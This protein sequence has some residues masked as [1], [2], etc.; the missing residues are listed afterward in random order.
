MSMNKVRLLLGSLP[1]LLVA[2]GLT[3]WLSIS[4]NP[5]YSGVQG[6]PGKGA[7][8]ATDDDD[9]GDSGRR[10]EIELAVKSDYSR[11]RVRKKDNVRTLGFVRDNGDEVI[12]SMVDLDRPH[13]LII[14]YTRFMFLS[15]LF[16][17]KQEKVLIVG[18]GGGAMIHFLKHYDPKVKIDVVEIDPKI[19]EIADKYFGVRSGG[20][21]NIITKDAFDYLKNTEARYD[22]IYMDAFLK[23]SNDTD[24][25]G[26]P[27]RLKTIRFYKEIQQ[28]LNP[29]G[30]VVYNLN[31]HAT[32]GEDVKTI[33][34]AFPQTYTYELPEWGG[35]VVVG[36]MVEQR[37]P[38][39]GLLKAAVELDRRFKTQFSFLEMARRETR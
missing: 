3:I 19:V 17:P 12:E 30:L 18:L 14:D 13:D 37:Q 31:P 16:R 4:Y 11:I 39:N 9:E 38:A 1:L 25:T 21:V 5:W 36:S 22:V 33:R 32:V 34:E 20:N 2:V 23:P 8:A 27:L 26:V 15:Y 24:K 7:P 29:A 10:G 35:Y 6:S 28:K